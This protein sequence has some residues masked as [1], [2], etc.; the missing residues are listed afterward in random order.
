MLFVQ[1]K[2][3]VEVQ[4]VRVLFVQEVGWVVQVVVFEVDQMKVDFV[5]QGVGK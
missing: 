1:V 4:M 2:D 3:L 5:V